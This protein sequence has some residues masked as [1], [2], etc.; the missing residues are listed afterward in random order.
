M[1][2]DVGENQIRYYTICSEATYSRD[3]KVGHRIAIYSRYGRSMKRNDIII[4]TELS[5]QER[6]PLGSFRSRVFSSEHPI[7]FF[8]P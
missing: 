7:R 8:R 5:P 6:S 1:K 2:K 3:N 4:T